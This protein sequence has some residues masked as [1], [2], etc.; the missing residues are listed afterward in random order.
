MKTKHTKEE[1]RKKEKKRK[2]KRKI[3]IAKGRKES[4]GKKDEKKGDRE[5]YGR[6]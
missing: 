3:N 2:R 4:D 5:N 1:E 6:K